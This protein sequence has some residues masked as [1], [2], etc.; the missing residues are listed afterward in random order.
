M[1]RTDRI[2]GLMPV[3][4]RLELTQY[5]LV[6]ALLKSRWMP[7]IPIVFNLFMFTIILM[8]GYYGGLAPGN[9]NFGIM[10]VWIVWWVVLMMVLVPGGS[11]AWCT[12]CP[13]PV[14]GE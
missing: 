3:D 14:L 11:R 4:W 10:I 2:L 6:R 12:A 1:F 9:Y 8:A 7:F 5:P 13:L